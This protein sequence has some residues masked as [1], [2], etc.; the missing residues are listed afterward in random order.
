MT[1]DI[2]YLLDRAD[3][4]ERA[5]GQLIGDMEESIVDLRRE[6]VTAVARQN[7][8]RK[9]LFAAEEAASRIECEATMALARGEELRARQVVGREIA[10]LKAR[11]AFELDLADA[12]QLSARLVAHLIRMEDRAQAARR[13]RDEI[14]RRGRAVDTGRPDRPD[15]APGSGAFEGYAQA[16]TALEVEA[17]AT[18]E[19]PALGHTSPTGSECCLAKA[20]RELEGGGQC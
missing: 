17:E 16:V 20:E 12:N 15:P 10:V 7:R 13:K 4:P 1:S 2:N 11:D 3:D 9:Q 8:I 5:I 19:R 14:V 18:R 6:T